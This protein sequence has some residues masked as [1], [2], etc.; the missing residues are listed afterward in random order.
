MLS[1]TSITLVDNGIMEQNYSNSPN[2]HLTMYMNQ[3]NH[4]QHHHH[5]HHQQHNH[6]NPHQH[7][8]SPSPSIDS[9]D[10]TGSSTSPYATETNVINNHSNHH[11]HSHHAHYDT[12]SNNDPDDELFDFVNW[13]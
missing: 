2:K 10:L 9:S 6:Q 5:Q 11:S 8:T 3:P 1:P 13:F 7:S 4:N 12:A